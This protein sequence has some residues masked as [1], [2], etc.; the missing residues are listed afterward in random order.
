MAAHFAP[1]DLAKLP[2]SLT[3]QDV[4][5]ALGVSKRLIYD[6]I[7]QPEFHVQ[8]WIKTGS[9]WRLPRWRLFEALGLT[10]P[11]LSEYVPR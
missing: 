7:E 11:A 10:D 5:N 6:Q 8:G 2:L 3:V 4:A 1:E 9:V